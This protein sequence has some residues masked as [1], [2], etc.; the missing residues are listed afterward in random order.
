MPHVHGD[1]L[2]MEG[3]ATERALLLE[4]CCAAISLPGVVNQVS[5]SLTNKRTSR[6]HTHG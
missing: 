5:L 6:H 4:L 3:L 1:P 2:P